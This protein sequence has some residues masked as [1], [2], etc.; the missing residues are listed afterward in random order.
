M[1]AS[2]K[3]VVSRNSLVKPYLEVKASSYSLIRL[4]PL[5][6]TQPLVIQTSQCLVLSVYYT[7]LF[8]LQAVSTGQLVYGKRGVREARD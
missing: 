7:A 1:R 5:P 8:S 4:P 6:G 2:Y 3:D